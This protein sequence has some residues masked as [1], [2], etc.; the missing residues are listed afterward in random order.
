MDAPSII[1]DCT[2][3]GTPIDSFVSLVERGQAVPIQAGCDVCIRQA[4]ELWLTLTC[5]TNV[6]S[7]PNSTILSTTWTDEDGDVVGDRPT[8]LVQDPGSYTCRVDFGNDNIDRATSSIGCRL[9]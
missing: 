1:R 8:L 6:A 5:R 4:A 3:V 9:L 2:G 7:F